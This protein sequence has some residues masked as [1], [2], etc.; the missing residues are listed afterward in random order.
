MSLGAFAEATNSL[1]TGVIYTPEGAAEMLHTAFTLSQPQS[2]HMQELIA[3]SPNS[4][5]FTFPL[6]LINNEL[7]LVDELSCF[8]IQNHLTSVKTSARGRELV[9]YR[10]V[11][12]AY[13]WFESDLTVFYIGIQQSDGSVNFCV[14]PTLRKFT[15]NYTFFPTSI[16]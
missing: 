8:D 6:L 9:I 12:D 5:L 2:S 1:T 16:C 11:G 15:P 13:S 4:K 10:A 7:T 3:S 14:T